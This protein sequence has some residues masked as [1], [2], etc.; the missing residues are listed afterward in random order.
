MLEFAYLESEHVLVNLRHS[1]FWKILSNFLFN[2]PSFWERCQRWGRRGKEGGDGV[3][4][5]SHASWWICSGWLNYLWDSKRNSTKRLFFF[6]PRNPNLIQTRQ[7]THVHV[8]TPMNTHNTKSLE[9]AKQLNKKHTNIHTQ[10]DFHN[11]L[12][13]CLFVYKSTIYEGRREKC[14]VK[15]V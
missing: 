13:L 3:W 6:S 5:I 8:H 11:D 4:F 12:H 9:L 15:Q 1:E 7:S 2:P 14:L 10:T